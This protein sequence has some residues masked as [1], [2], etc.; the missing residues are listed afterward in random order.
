MSIRLG[1]ECKTDHESI[2]MVECLFMFSS[3][4]WRCS[5]TRCLDYSD[6]DIYLEQDFLLGT[7]TPL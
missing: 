7:I 5:L 3:F 6:L 1:Q 4:N 2:A